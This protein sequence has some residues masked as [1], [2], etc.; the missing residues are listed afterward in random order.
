MECSRALLPKLSRTRPDMD[1]VSDFD[2]SDDPGKP[3]ERDLQAK[4]K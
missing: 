2:F 1:V 4:Y 3:D